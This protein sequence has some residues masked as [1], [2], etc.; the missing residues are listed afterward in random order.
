MAR[1]P[2][3]IVGLSEANTAVANDYL[4]IEK[5]GA[6]NTYVTSKIKVSNF[7]AIGGPY[8]NDSVANTNGIDVNDF[9]YTANGDVKIRL[10]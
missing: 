1:L 2:K 10:V 9:Y 6:G 7:N 8:A 5:A 4:V 3:K